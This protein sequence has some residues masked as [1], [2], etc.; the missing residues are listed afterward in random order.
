[1]IGQ[2]LGRYT[3]V[4]KIGAGG[5]GVVYRAHDER[6]DRDVALKVLPPGTF[7]DKAVRRR[8]RKE[9]LA[10]SHLNHPNIATVHDFDTQDGVDFLVMELVPGS[11]LD[12][13]LSAG[14][15]SEKET[16][17]L[18]VQLA[19][20][21]SLAHE[22]G[23]VHR[24]LKPGNLRVTPDGRL[25]IL[26]FGLAKLLQPTVHSDSTTSV[27]T[28]VVGTPPYMAP[29]QL[30]GERVDSRTD[31]Y[32]GGTVLY[33]M[34][35]GLRPFPGTQLPRLIEAILHQAPQPPR[36]VNRHLSRALESIILK[37]LEKEPERRY[38]S[39]RELQV[40]LERLSAPVPLAAPPRRL[41]RHRWLPVLGGA[42]E[43]IILKALE[44]EP[45]RRYQSARELQVDLERL[46][47]PVPLAAP[48]RR[49]LRSRWLP[50][51]GG[52]LA[53]TLA[54][55]VALL[56]LNVGGWRERLLGRAGP[57]NERSGLSTGPVKGRRAIA[58][59][60]F[61]N[62][63]GRPDQAWLSTAFSETLTTELAAGEQLRTIP[64]ENVARTK[65][66]LSLPDAESYGKDTL[67]RICRNLGTD[68]VVL[69]SYLALGEKGGG[70]I[71]LD[72]R[73]QNASSGET[74]ATETDTGLEAELFD[75]VSRNGARLR[76]R[77][78]V[79]EV[80]VAEAT[81]VRATLPSNP[82][83]VR[84]YSEGLASL[85]L[86]DVREAREL[87]EKAVA[88]DPNY[89]LVHSALA[90]AW[91]ALG[92]DQKAKAE[93]KRAFEL[94]ANLSRQE[95]LWVEGQ[96][97][98]T[99]K[100]RD[101]AI[102]IYRTL[103]DFFP[104]NLDYGLR[105]AYA[106]TSAGGGKVALATIDVLR[107]FLPPA[108]D[109]PRI[110]LAES[111]AAASVSD[112]R[113]V[114]MAAQRAVTKGQAQGARLVI[115]RARMLEGWAFRNLGEPKKATELLDDARR[116]YA[117]VGDRGSV[118]RVLTRLAGAYYDQ[119]DLA[120]VKRMFEE[121]LTIQRQIGDKA[122]N[123]ASLN[124]IGV[125]LDSQ[126]DLVGAKPMYE[127]SLAIAREIGNRDLVSRALNNIAIVLKEQG[128]LDKARVT[129]EQSL[130]IAREIGDKES[131]SRTYGNIAV[132]LIKQG[133]LSGAKRMYEQSLAISREIDNKGL[134]A[135]ALHNLGTVL[136]AQG[137]LADARKSHEEAL[138]IRNQ[139]GEKTQAAESRLRLAALS[140]EEEHPAEAEVLAH[141]A[142]EEFGKN[143]L[144]GDEANAHAVLARSFLAK[145]KL[146]AAERSVA[147]ATT[148]AATA[149][150]RDIFLS[151][152]ICAARVRAASGKRTEAV[153]NLEAIIPEA[154][155]LG[156][157]EDEFEARLAIGEIEIESGRAAAGRARLAA[158]E[159]DAAARGFLLIARK[160]AAARQR[161]SQPC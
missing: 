33:E 89:A 135:Q 44:K 118:A 76:R 14:A 125:V 36:V 145:G 9:A 29:E 143:K 86:F 46:S 87:L 151:V 94:S 80:S 152:A 120:A 100:E 43:S 150:E 113:R 24:D 34:A 51:L 99:T 155:K 53:I 131:I 128:D 137:N 136:S 117:A 73:L 19:Q 18:G 68:F 1:M 40:D 112:Y 48:P 4:E 60:G 50:A 159:R 61:K 82:E 149:Q 139:I 15:L 28:P 111:E 25:K 74:I 55:L 47:A 98:E 63:S 5:M 22:Q 114:Q 69:G 157:V 153:N 141:E 16:L 42:L 146:A 106:Q 39:A 32:A 84:L 30:R 77:L 54:I 124:G 52:T 107:K 161:K 56:G 21:L 96:Y 95:R 104:D 154:A 121:S 102:E 156:F 26:D 122:G 160:A 10:L 38:Q 6:L 126:G 109:D 119:G 129:Y 11:T 7:G 81:A 85:R 62:L 93:A 116:T 49:L 58:V 79:G 140:L 108:Q 20:G 130:A 35:T 88:A 78:G 148:L 59:L 67:A 66:D 57:G 37:A 103:F 83:A 133:D 12:E 127:Q 75:L 41:L 13:K 64:G 144:N 72:L 2:K 8:F 147:L 27:E 115:A 71:R 65:I 142:A 70:K 123:A 90:A 134:A 132:I 45:E 91:S 23:V 138:A 105:L 101:K 3:I 31:I 110:D 17:R 92:Y 158:L 97:R